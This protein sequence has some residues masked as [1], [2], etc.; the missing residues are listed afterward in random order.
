MLATFNE[1]IS[2]ESVHSELEQNPDL[3]VLDFRQIRSIGREGNVHIACK[4]KGKTAGQKDV[5][6]R[7]DFCFSEIPICRIKAKGKFWLT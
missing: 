1:L 5:A 7:V 4:V 6:M 2:S 3:L